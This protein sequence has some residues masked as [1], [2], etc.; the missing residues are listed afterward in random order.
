MAYEVQIPITGNDGK[1]TT[2][3]APSDGAPTDGQ[4]TALYSAVDGLILGV[5]KKS[6]LV[7]RTDKDA[8]SDALPASG[9]A[10]RTTKWL[11][12]Y[13]DGAGDLRHLEIGTADHAL[14]TP[15]SDYVDLTAGAGLAF[16]TAFEALTINGGNPTVVSIQAVG[17][18]G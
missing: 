8:G 16:V 3:T 4:I 13:T 9:A 12:R 17:R 5:E 7:E 6:V 10:Q 18:T 1:T 11:V 15:P 14:T 2:F